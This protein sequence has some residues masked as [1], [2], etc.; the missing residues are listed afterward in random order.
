MGVLDDYIDA[1]ADLCQVALDRDASVLDLAREPDKQAR[2]LWNRL[3]SAR[4]ELYSTGELQRSG[5]S[6]LL[7]IGLFVDREGIEREAA[8]IAALELEEE[9]KVTR[10]RRS[11]EPYHKGQPLFQHVPGLWDLVRVDGKRTPELLLVDGERTKLD[12]SRQLIEASGIKSRLHNCLAPALTRWLDETVPDACFLRADPYEVGTGLLPNLL[13][14]AIHPAD[15]KWWRSLRIW[16]SHRQVAIYEVLD[17][18]PAEDARR[19]WEYRVRN[20]GRL[21]V[22]FRRD[23][24]GTLSGSIEELTRPTGALTIGYYLHLTSDAAVG[25]EWDMATAAHIDGAINV[26]CAG[27]RD[28][29]QRR[30]STRTEGGKNIDATFRTHLFRIDEQPLCYVIPIAERFFRSG[31]LVDEWLTDQFRLPRA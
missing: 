1:Q 23:T 12:Q 21:E 25:E 10:L 3:I 14:A 8:I 20:M 27:D 15:P 29:A 13:E 11:C 30:W 31:L 28:A 24:S 22:T 17:C 16:P 4:L 18:E 7:A 2:E 26:Y 9:V 6:G 5:Y 19:F